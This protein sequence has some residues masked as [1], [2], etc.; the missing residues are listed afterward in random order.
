MTT[1]GE[2]IL[3]A[4]R[5]APLDDDVLAV[6]LEV[7]SRQA[8]NQ[9]ARRL[10]LAGRLRRHVGP[11]GKIVN[12]WIAP[13]ATMLTA[14]LQ[15]KVIPKTGPLMSEDKVK[16]AVRGWLTE[17]GFSVAVAM[18]R[19]RGIDID[20]KHPD[21]RRW[22]I[23]AKGEVASNQQQ[24]NYFLGAM[25]ELLQRMADPEP[26]YALALP[27]NRRYR[28]LVRRLPAL[29]RQRIG[30]VVLWVDT[31]LGNQTV[32]ADWPSEDA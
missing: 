3:E 25:G 30:L 26:T 8:V 14:V 7:S 32:T 18:G 31:E 1:L 23:E 12:E 5:Y 27:S 19:E 22:I 21:G 13:G 28:G 17:Q 6:R 2:R 4:I 11:E 20:A 10:E 15:P 16:D 29:A 24:G 9:A